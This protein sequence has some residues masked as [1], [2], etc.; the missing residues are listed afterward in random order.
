[1][2]ESQSLPPKMR[3]R[4][5]PKLFSGVEMLTAY[6]KNVHHISLPPDI[7]SLETAPLQRL[8]LYQH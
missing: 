5:I 3:L 8:L 7:Y 6:A 2:E 1:M 4:T